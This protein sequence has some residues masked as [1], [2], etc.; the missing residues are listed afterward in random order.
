MSMR[1]TPTSKIIL[2]TQPRDGLTEN[3]RGWVEFIRIISEDTDPPPTLEGVQALR[4]AIRRRLA[5]SRH[6]GWS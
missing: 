4:T 1:N 5:G 3:E 2:R 6:R